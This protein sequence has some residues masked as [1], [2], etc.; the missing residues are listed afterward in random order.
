MDLAWQ[1]DIVVG[2][3]FGSQI[4]SY[5]SYVTMFGLTMVAS[6]MYWCSIF[7]GTGLA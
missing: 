1:P 4:V 6:D 5:P 7:Y 2:I 3:D